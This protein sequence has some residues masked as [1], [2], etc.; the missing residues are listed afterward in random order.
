MPREFTIS[1]FNA[2]GRT[3][4]V[5]THENVDEIEYVMD[6]HPLNP[7]DQETVVWDGLAA[8]GNL[9]PPGTYYYVVEMMIEQKDNLG[10]VTG[11]DRQ[12]HKDYIVVRH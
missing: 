1:I 2:L 11:T 4:R 8:N 12:E 6:K 9:V 7:G 3:V 10:N 5:I